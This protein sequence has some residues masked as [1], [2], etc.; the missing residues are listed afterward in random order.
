[1][2]KTLTVLSVAFLVASASIA[3]PNVEHLVTL[4]PADTVAIVAVD[5]AALRTQPTI[6]AWLMEHQAPWS[7]VDDEA[8][9]FLTE[10]GLDPVR[11]V[12]AMVIA[13]RSHDEDGKAL[14]LFSGRYDPTSL[15][16]ALKKR[17]AQAVTIG[18]ST[19]YRI[20]GHHDAEGPI[21]VS[22]PD[23]VLVGDQTL[24]SAALTP[25]GGANPA[26]QKAVSS[27]QLDLRAPF[28]MIVD[29]P[30]AAREG[31]RK[32]EI[33]SDNPDVQAMSG[34]MRAS[35][36]V[37]SVVMYARL[38]DVLE[39]H[40]HA[41]ADSVENAELLR[42][43]VKGALA[44]MRLQVQNQQPE[45]VDVLRAVDVRVDGPSISV[46]G[47]VPVSLL[48]KIA[49]GMHCTERQHGDTHSKD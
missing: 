38:S 4:L 9:G 6:Q 8:A 27:G 36:S 34:V 43:A 11:D 18:D 17:G 44:V 25:K 30:E 39:I 41:L 16:A 2:R 12:D 37:R 5:V 7:G 10:A 23:L 22:T 21:L 13:I 26:V 24:L 49:H 20:E 19:G 35:A 46:D 1:M 3:A 47:S 15:A 40:T 32:A 45:L 28:W 33:P 31:M 29:V 42:D 14:A 48:E